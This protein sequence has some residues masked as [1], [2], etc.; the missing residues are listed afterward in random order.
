[1]TTEVLDAVDAISWSDVLLQRLQSA[2]ATL[3]AKQ[4]LRDEKSWLTSAIERLGAARADAGDVLAR[5]MRLPE[6]ESLRVEHAE[7]L[8]NAAVD[9]VERLH[10]GITFHAGTRA[11]ML[12]ALYGKVKL[13]TM[14]RADRD[15]FEK[16]CA[17]FEKRLNSSYVKRML[18]EAAFAFATPVIEEL[19]AAF[20]AWR[21]A[22]T[23][24]PIPDTEAAA[25]R[26]EV[27]GR[28]RR[29][30]L[31]LTQARL[32]AEA[33]LAPL[34][35]AFDEAGLGQRPRRRVVRPA[36][37]GQTTKPKNT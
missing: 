19:R 11:P 15:D 8:Q 7:V 33:A 32:L 5:A 27:L 26:D 20:T 12:E 35:N 10:A 4:G 37:Q 1:M 18:G 25:L 36:D 28:A 21:G 3:G 9:A 17:D 30:E 23:A 6:L 2:E 16:F 14:R 13:P 29:L 22:F 24:E 31:P 34:K